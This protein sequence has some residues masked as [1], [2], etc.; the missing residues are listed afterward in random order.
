MKGIKKAADCI[1]NSQNCKCYAYH[2]FANGAWKRKL[3]GNSKMRSCICG[4][5][6]VGKTAVL[7]RQMED[8]FID[9]Y[10]PTIFDDYECVL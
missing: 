5:G 1:R 4:D 6:G 9:D 3:H 8:S 10:Q 7:Q 2:H